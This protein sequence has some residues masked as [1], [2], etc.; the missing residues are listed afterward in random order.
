MKKA[1]FIVAIILLATSLNAIAD[2][3]YEL[4]WAQD[5]L[6]GGSFNAYITTSQDIAGN[7]YMTGI[8]GTEAGYTISMPSPA[9]LQNAGFTVNQLLYPTNSYFVGFSAI[10]WQLS[11]GDFVAITQEENLLLFAD[12][13]DFELIATTSNGGSLGSGYNGGFGYSGGALFTTAS[14]VPLPASFILFASGL[15][16]LGASMRQHLTKRLSMVSCN[17]FPGKC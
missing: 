12:P 6:F 1:E 3:E 15:L 11:N 17:L 5:P 13:S 2:G 16:G 7:T 14:S 10:A 9:D 8:S 4:T